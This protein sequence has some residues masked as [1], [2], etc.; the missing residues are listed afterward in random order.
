MQVKYGKIDIIKKSLEAKYDLLFNVESGRTQFKNHGEKDFADITPEVVKSFH[1]ELLDN[2]ISVTL[3]DVR[4]ALNMTFF[5]KQKDLGQ[6]EEIEMLLDTF[7]D[8]RFNIIKQKPEYLIRGQMENFAP[9]ER[10][11]MNS[12]NRY[13]RSR[14]VKTSRDALNEILFSDYS[15]ISNPIKEY[16][17]QLPQ[18]NEKETN[19]ILE[20]A[21]TVETKNSEKWAEYLKKWLVA[22]VANAMI[23]ENCKNHTMLVLTGEQGA[24]KTTWLDNLCPVGLRQYLYTGKIDPS[25]KDT[26]TLL[27]EFLLV[28][29]DDQLKQ[30]NKKD[31]NDLKNMITAPNVKYRRP[32]DVFIQEYPHVCSFMG[33]VNGNEFLTDPTGSRRFLAFE[34]V[35]IH[36]EKAKELNMDLVWKQAYHLFKS[37]LQYWFSRDEIEQLHASNAEF[38]VISMEEQFLLKYFAKPEHR[39]LATHYLQPAEILSIIQINTNVRIRQKTLGEALIKHGFEKWRLTSG[40][41]QKWVYSVIQLNNEQIYEQQTAKK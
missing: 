41:Q 6:Y 36:I 9:L 30:L 37:N 2:G 12:I 3:T 14:G 40:N 27:A 13:I 32:Y 18:Y 22:V 4:K 16:F 28:N 10:Y 26:Q 20:L 11:S 33:S 19:Y 29:V 35:K 5:D 31:E 24:F 38:Q 1:T 7:M 34:V 23:D 25:N 8:C 15:I 17:E 21:N 39:D